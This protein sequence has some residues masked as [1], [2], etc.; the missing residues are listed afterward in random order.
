MRK[1]NV[2]DNFLFEWVDLLNSSKVTSI[3]LVESCLDRI[4]KYDNKIKS[5][6]KV[7]LDDAL[8]NA[9]ESDKRRSKGNQY[10]IIDGIPFAAK[11]N[12]EIK[13]KVAAA[14]MLSRKEIIS[15]VN[16]KA[17]ELL[18]EAGAINLGHLNMHEAALGSTNDNPLHGKTYNPHMEG[19]TPG[20]SS[21]GSGAAVASGFSLFSLGTDTLGSI[22]IPAAYCGVSGI[23]PSKGLVSL[24]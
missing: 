24:S 21:G 16:S 19:F 17:I 7:F 15:K 23:K 10:S 2:L 6:T 12:I 8:R 11:E 3:Q 20:G 9:S 13:N 4:N 22:R 18:N 1:I 14:G 5:F